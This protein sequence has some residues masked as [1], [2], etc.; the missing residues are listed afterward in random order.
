M[1]DAKAPQLNEDGQE[2][3]FKAAGGENGFA[4]VHP[5]GWIAFMLGF[6]WVLFSGGFGMALI[7]LWAFFGL[8]LAIAIIAPFVIAAPG[9]L[10]SSKTVRRHS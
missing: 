5:K 10:W 6:A 7:V 8:P 4:P 1:S 9:L 3:W 2:I